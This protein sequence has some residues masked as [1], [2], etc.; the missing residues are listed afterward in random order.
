M[1]RSG[2]RGEST[3]FLLAAP[4][5]LYLTIFFIVP[6]LLVI[7]I[8][9]LTRGQASSDYAFP[10]TLENYQDIFQQPIW[11]IFIRSIRIALVSTVICLILGY[12]LAFFIG[13]RRKTWVKQMTLFLVILPFWTN[14]L[15]RTYAW[16]II[17]GR[18]GVLNEVLVNQL[19]LMDNG[20]EILGTETAVILG[21]VYGYL[22]F[23][24][25]PIYAVVERFPFH[26]VE[27][28]KDLGGDDWSVFW[29]VV[30]PLTLPGVV[31]GWILVFIP[32]IGAFITPNLLGGTQGY[33]IGNYINSQFTEAG[34]SWTVGAGSSMVMMLV[35]SVALLLY[36]R[37]ASDRPAH[38]PRNAIER[39]FAQTTRTILFPVNWISHRISDLAQ[40]L[41][42][43]S[44]PGTVSQWKVRRARAVNVL[45]RAFGWIDSIFCYLFLW[46]PIILLVLYSFNSS[47]RVS[48]QWQGF[49]TD[50]YT[51]ILNGISGTGGDFSTD[52]LLSSLETS[53]KISIASTLIAV[54]L[55]TTIALAMVRGRFRGKQIFRGLLYL[56]V[57]IPDIT[58]AVSLIIFFQIA[59]GALESLLGTRYFPGMVT[60]IVGHVAFN[61]TYV[62]VVVTAR[63]TN[64]SPHYEEAARDLG[65]NN[66]QTF[67]LVTY[68][69]I[70]PGIIAGALLAFTLSLDDFVITFFVGGGTTTTLPV[71]VWS[72]IRRGISPEINVVS[73]LMILAS[74]ILI[75]LSLLM[76]GQGSRAKGH[77]YDQS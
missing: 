75:A 62:A 11:G 57:T 45:G 49:T 21:L 42:P 37:F 48:G 32:S 7:G 6:L 36:V 43:S 2:T 15:I 34:G 50:W 68:P 18:R 51:E 25:L 41:Q 23:M 60:V 12:P 26:L 54:I 28:G 46:I 16:Q 70:L 76:Q 63:L 71:Y 38:T 5:M 44:A 74:L 40:S 22:P 66:F 24:V 19:G 77:T 17:L 69:L 67:R 10:L 31:V 9:L 27:A 14:F 59:F 20:L 61:I 33:M 64:M 73:T 47:R 55:G 1:K 13:T 52:R 65:M 30:F 72:L 29:E 58:L 56:P 35:V 3:G 53:F 4:A 8:S 39:F